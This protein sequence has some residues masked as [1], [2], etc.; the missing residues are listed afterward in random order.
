MLCGRNPAS[1][2]GELVIDANSRLH[3]LQIAANYFS[4]GEFL[5][6]PRFISLPAA[7]WLSL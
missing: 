2:D 3:Y 6:R 7:A 5:G 4:A 1:C